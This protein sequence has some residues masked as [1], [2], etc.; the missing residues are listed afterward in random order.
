MTE[1]QIR[2]D[3]RQ[4]IMV[5]IETMYHKMRSDREKLAGKIT[6]STPNLLKL[7]HLFEGGERCCLLINALIADKSSEEVRLDNISSMGKDF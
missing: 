3:E 5:L 1:L 7:S 4:K 6:D 2:I